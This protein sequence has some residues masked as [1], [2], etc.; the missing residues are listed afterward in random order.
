MG[1]QS[2]IERKITEMSENE[3]R[4]QA[5]VE[6]LKNERDAKVLEYQRLFDQERD[7][8]KG[9]IQDAEQKYREAESRRNGLVFEHEKEKAKWNLERD[10]LANQKNELTEMITKLEKKKETLLRENEKLKNE[11]KVSRRSINLAPGLVSNNL[12]GGKNSTKIRTTSPAHSKGSSIS[13]DKNLSDITNFPKPT[14]D[15]QTS[16][17]KTTNSTSVTSEDEA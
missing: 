17:T 4:L 15:T 14:F 3:K 6:A 10:H 1:S 2:F 12:Y 7:Q 13:L 5:E 9:K 8:L 16:F 11:T